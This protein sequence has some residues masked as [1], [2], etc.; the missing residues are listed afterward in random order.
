M[1]GKM[2]A[3]RDE[4][5]KLEKGQIDEYKKHPM[6]NLAD[7]INRS[8]IW[9]FGELTKGSMLT[10]ILTTVIIIGIPLLLFLISR[11]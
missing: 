11:F 5:D 2:M 3:I 4:K 7:S 8:T 10:R 1:E 9:N 6:I